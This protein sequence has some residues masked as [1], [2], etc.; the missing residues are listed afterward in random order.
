MIHCAPRTLLD[1]AR[2]LLASVFSEL[3]CARALL[4]ENLGVR[5]CRMAEKPR[6]PFELQNNMRRLVASHFELVIR[7]LNFRVQKPRSIKG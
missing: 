6:W 4:A 5:N 2:R 1:C 3:H 7:S